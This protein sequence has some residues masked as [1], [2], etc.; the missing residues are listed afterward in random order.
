MID[1]IK[2]CICNDNGILSLIVIVLSCIALLASIYAA[3]MPFKK[4]MILRLQ[5]LH[6]LSHGKPIP[7]AYQIHVVNVGNVPLSIEYVGLAY[8]ENGELHR[9]IDI[10]NPMK[11]DVVLGINESFDVPYSYVNKSQ[12][13][14]KKMFLMAQEVSGKV[15]KLSYRKM[16][17]T[18][19]SI[20]IASASDM[21]SAF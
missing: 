21:V 16:I 15:H 17:R 19:D 7:L 14:D 2:F 13:E 20:I 6:S 9:F 10:E 11:H 12:I 8:R 3:G 4:K 18:K 1:F 5:I